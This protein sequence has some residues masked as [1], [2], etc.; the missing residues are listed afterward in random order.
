[1]S[2]CREFEVMVSLRAAG[3]T[4]GED[5]RLLDVHLTRCDRCRREA[6]AIGAALRLAK[7]PSPS[8]VERRTAAD[9]AER[10]LAAWERGRERRS[11]ARRIAFTAAI[12]AA[13]VLAL[14]VPI[15]L[16]QPEPSP[17]VAAAD[18]V[19][20]GGDVVTPRV[21]AVAP[22][23]TDGWQVPDLDVLW[24][25]AAVVSAELATEPGD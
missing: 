7:V 24:A 22:G 18:V 8:Q 3:A 11:V 2:A 14:V 25:D 5:A 23:S 4:E 20:L 10:T 9:L 13:F 6:L 12:S 17:E 21:P 16:L 15:S 19:A 1:M